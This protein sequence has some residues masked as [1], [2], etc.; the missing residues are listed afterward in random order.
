MKSMIKTA[1]ALADIVVEASVTVEL[2]IQIRS[3]IKFNTVNDWRVS[4]YKKKM[5]IYIEIKIQR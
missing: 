4:D 3:M 1:I 5:A 2:T